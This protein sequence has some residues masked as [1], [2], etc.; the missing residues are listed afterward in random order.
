MPRLTVEDCDL[1]IESLNFTIRAFNDYQY[2]SYEF[3]QARI[4]EAETAQRK[5]RALRKQ[6]K[7]EFTNGL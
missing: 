4:K 5:I 6:I 1:I 7:A 3:K 2:P